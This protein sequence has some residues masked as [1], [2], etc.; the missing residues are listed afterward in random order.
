MSEE[1]DKKEATDEVVVEEVVIEEKTYYDEDGEEVKFPGDPE[2]IKKQLEGSKDTSSKLKELQTNQDKLVKELEG[3]KDKDY[4]FNKLRAK[5]EKG[6][7][8]LTTTEKIVLDQQGK[9]D[10][11]NSKI[12]GSWN[13]DALNKVVG[14]D[15]E[16]RK[17]VQEAFD[18]LNI[19]AETESEIKEKYDKAYLLVKGSSPKNNISSVARDLG[20]VPP[21]EG[22]KVSKLS[23]ELKE[24]G[25]NLGLTEEDNK[26]YNL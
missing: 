20:G 9:I 23:P 15:A 21:I 19:T 25:K 12:S 18:T 8:K 17:K 16:N 6:K 4:N 13:N 2:S 24:L 5:Q 11:M 14:S 1:K 22:T 3:Y 7:E 26:K 10:A